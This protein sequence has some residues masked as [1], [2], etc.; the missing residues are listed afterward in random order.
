MHSAA[1]N[2]D[3]LIARRVIRDLWASSNKKS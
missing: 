1:I 3:S 2:I